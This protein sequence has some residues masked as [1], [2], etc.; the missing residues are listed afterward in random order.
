M[1]LR[2]WTGLLQW[3]AELDPCP[4]WLVKVAQEEIHEWVWVMVSSFLRE[5][6]SVISQGGG[7]VPC[8]QGGFA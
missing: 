2:K 7:I 1:H 3:L 8:P 4:S 6:G 5:G